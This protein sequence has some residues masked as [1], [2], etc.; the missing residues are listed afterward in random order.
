VIPLTAWFHIPWDPGITWESS[1]PLNLWIP[2]HGPVSAS[3]FADKMIIENMEIGIDL[4]PPEPPHL[5]STNLLRSLTLG[6]WSSSRY[7]PDQVTNFRHKLL[8]RWSL[9]NLCSCYVHVMLMSAIDEIFVN[10]LTFI[11]N[12]SL[13]IP[14][15]CPMLWIRGCH[16]LYPNILKYFLFP[17]NP[18]L[19]TKA[20]SSRFLICPIVHFMV[21]F[22][23]CVPWLSVGTLRSHTRRCSTVTVPVK[24]KSLSTSFLFQNPSLWYF[25]SELSL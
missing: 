20:T 8:V 18:L 7:I 1:W 10:I 22:V 25:S 4:D 19:S 16:T 11:L 2:V 21:Q 24:A 6:K 15:I 13:N 3:N 17:P 9:L 14:W 5:G 23:L 12:L